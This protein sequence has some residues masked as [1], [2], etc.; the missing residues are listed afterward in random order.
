MVE[1]DA[2]TIAIIAGAA[3]AGVVAVWQTLRLRELQWWSRV[4]SEHRLG[5][6]R[7]YIRR[8]RETSEDE[9]VPASERKEAQFKSAGVKP[10]HYIDRRQVEDLYPRIVGRL[11]KETVYSAGTE[12]AAEF[13]LDYGIKIG[14]K[15]SGSRGVTMTYE[16]LGAPAAYRRLQQSLIQANKVTFGLEE[17][18][19]D[20]SSIEEVTSNIARFR[21]DGLAI[22]G[23]DE[24]RYVSEKMR[25]SALEYLDDIVSGAEGYVAI[26]AEFSVI[27]VSEDTQTRT[28]TYDHPINEYLSDETE[29]VVFQITCVEEYL[30]PAAKT[31]FTEGST[32]P[33][34]CIGRIVGWD[35]NRT[36]K[37][38][39]IAIS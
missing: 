39:P 7:N 2:V 31:V 5:Q 30:T 12:T 8:E 14:A 3:A 17:F 34:T 28:M 32:I 33:L 29:R 25:E 6:Y 18:D 38:T 1:F 23:E 9:R 36:L 37:I 19:F 4:Q 21:Q 35:N 22:T 24:K 20:E 13:G 26:M 16:Q 10:F 27:D 15:R 11:A